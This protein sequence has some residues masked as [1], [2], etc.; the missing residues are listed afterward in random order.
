MKKAKEPSAKLTKEMASKIITKLATGKPADEEVL[1]FSVGREKLLQ[2][3]D[4]KLQE[5][6]NSG[7]SDVKFISADYGQGKTHFL[8]MI[9][10]VALQHNFVVSKVELHSRDVPFDKFEI[11][12]QQIMRHLSATEFRRE[13]LEKLLNSWAERY[14]AK[15]A[16]D[17]YRILAEVPGV[18][19]DLR[20]ALVHYTLSHNDKAGKQYEK[21]LSLLSWF[22]G[23]KMNAAFRNE[24]KIMNEISATNVKEILHGF[25]AFLRHMGY[26]GFIVMLDEAEAITSLTRL[27]KRDLANENIRKII[28]N[29]KDTE[30]F[31]FVFASTPTFLS[32]DDE[33]GAQTYD[34]LWRRIRSPLPVKAT[35]LHAVIVELPR[36]S[37][38]EFHRLALRIKEIFEV[39][40][41]KKTTKVTAS[42]LKLLASYVQQ[43]TDQRVGTMVRSTVSVLRDS[44]ER[45]FDF[46]KR[47]QVVVEN[48]ISEEERERAEA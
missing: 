33:R 28:D 29:D 25:T 27:D 18:S 20:K 23:D 21:C 8:D 5:I 47:Y 42:D 13:A 36:L 24:F 30:G 10:L 2:Y 38:E 46:A 43:R 22:Q 48:V 4:N 40:E 45:G 34:A 31:Y 35:S 26:A 7:V 12:F 6:R 14:S 32:G 1:L 41:E 3:F 15:G 44:L 37:E 11:V 17:L 16:S 39:A 19:P 9:R